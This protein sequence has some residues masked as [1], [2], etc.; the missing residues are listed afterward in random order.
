MDAN[1][2]HNVG[3]PSFP[4]SR[5]RG[6]WLER[7]GKR[8]PTY[9]K[10]AFL[11]EREDQNSFLSNSFYAFATYPWEREAQSSATPTAENQQS[12]KSKNSPIDHPKSPRDLRDL[13]QKNIYDLIPLLILLKW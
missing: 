1:A 11:R 7:E 3:P 5:T 4:S 2:K 6:A 9:A 8:A 10:A 12:S 13:N